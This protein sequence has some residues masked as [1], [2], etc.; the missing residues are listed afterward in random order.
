[1]MSCYP[2]VESTRP[3]FHC[4]LAPTTDC[5]EQDLVLNI[6]SL[7]HSHREGTIAVLGHLLKVL[8]STQR[9]N[10]ILLGSTMICV[11]IIP[12]VELLFMQH[13]LDSIVEAAR[14][15]WEAYLQVLPWMI[16]FVGSLFATTLLEMASNIMNTDIEEKLR[17]L[18]QRQII[19]HMQEVDLVYLEEPTFYDMFRRANEDM[20][21]RLMTVLRGLTDIASG[22]I[23]VG[24]ILIVLTSS[25]WLLVPLL[26]VG[27][28]PG[29]WARMSM[30]TRTHATYRIRTPLYRKARYLR[31]VLTN[32]EGAKEV[33]L[34]GLLDHLRSM[35]RRNARAVAVERRDLIVR[36]SWLEGGGGIVSA[37]AHGLAIGFLSWKATMSSLTVGS[38][39]MLIRAV[40]LFS[41]RFEQLML[42]LNLLQEQALYLGDLFEFLNV[43]V[44][45]TRD[46]TKD[47]INK[48]NTE[49]DLKFVD[50]SF[51][52]PGSDQY[53]LKDINL[54]IRM[55]EKVAFVGGNGAGK[56]TLI[57]LMMGLYQPTSG[58]ILLG[59]CPLEEWPRE[60]LLSHFAAVFQDF[61]KYHFSVRENIAFGSLDR[62]TEDELQLAAKKA[63]AAEFIDVLPH[64]YDTLLGRPFGG[65]ELSIG[66][67]QKL[68]I[69]RGLLRQAD[70]VILD[71]PTSALDPKS[72]A[73]VFRRFLEMT[74]DRTSVLISHRLG[75]IRSVDRVC[76]FR[77]GLLVEE[78]SHE[79]L[80]KQ[81][82]EYRSLFELQARWY[83]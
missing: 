19:D 75:S 45:T 72:E 17:I 43:E 66:E 63:G 22:A 28:V 6:S 23:A 62:F 41:S 32:R 4:R 5:R 79:Q 13:M 51:K 54:E 37:V 34:F 9:R 7:A 53:A 35:W 15:D 76:V 55:G 3:C 39:G 30:H 46:G 64:R 70:F 50:V 42:S 77:S 31:D 82:G 67:W 18:F 20:S 65:V 61:S 83:A 71:E 8:V 60:E 11:G 38:F 12:A 2:G 24:S 58:R 59:N 14:T 78:G 10:S 69:A 49:L 16:A 36:R 68:A 21:V 56:S 25:H 26:V 52:Y 57:R 80:I 74:H 29:I 33:R 27:S 48:S 1:M 40:Q 47:S 81:D 73:F 44:V